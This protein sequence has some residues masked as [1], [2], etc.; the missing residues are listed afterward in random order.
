M[1]ELSTID[2]IRRLKESDKVQLKI[3]GCY[4]LLKVHLYRVGV[5]SLC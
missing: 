5:G 1:G 4:E 2:K 3:R